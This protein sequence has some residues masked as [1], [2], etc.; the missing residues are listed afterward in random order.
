M[1]VPA[2]L[3]PVGIATTTVPGSVYLNTASA[4]PYAVISDG[5]NGTAIANGLTRSTAG[6]ISIGTNVTNDTSIQMCHDAASV[7]MY[8][9]GI[10]IG[11]SSGVN[12][13]VSIGDA[14]SVSSCSL[15][16][17]SQITLATAA[18]GGTYFI[19]RYLGFGS[20]ST[21]NIGST[22]VGAYTINIGASS[23]ST[24]GVY[25]IGTGL[26]TGTTNTIN[27]GTGHAGTGASAI[28][29][30]NALGKA[31][32]GTATAG[33]DNILTLAT[34]GY[35]DDAVSGGVL[36][37]A[38]TTVAGKI[39]LNTASA[40]PYAVI[41]DGLNG[42]AIAN[43]LT[44]STAGLL[45]IGTNAT[46]DTSITIGSATIKARSGAATVGA[47]N[48]LTLA[49][50]G[51][52]DS[53]AGGAVS[54][55]TTTV[56]GTVY[57]NSAAV[58]PYA[59]IS[60]G[61]GGFAVAGGLTRGSY[62][63][64]ALSIGNQAVDTSIVIGSGSA[65]AVGLTGSAININTAGGGATNIGNASAGALSVTADHL[66]ITSTFTGGG[67]ANLNTIMVPASQP[68]LIIDTL[69]AGAVASIIC[70]NNGVEGIVINAATGQIT[71]K[72]ATTSGD[73]SLVLATKGYV[74]AV[75]SA[76]WTLITSFNGTYSGTVRVT[77]N[78][79]IASMR[80]YVSSGITPGG[81]IPFTLGAAFRPSSYASSHFTQCSDGTNYF[82]SQTVINTA[83][84]V[85]V[86]YIPTYG[87][88]GPTSIAAN[89][90]L[91]LD[92]M[93]RI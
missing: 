19:G 77:V 29:I 8:G 30:G 34:K 84:D 4:T 69:T 66:Y 93:W 51:Y 64:G 73:T 88:S 91:Y 47:D 25:N 92:C 50:K 76:V 3:S 28:T 9:H 55:A 60:D 86:T 87:T 70:Y 23:A 54:I 27:I 82:M 85:T 16:S 44:R 14:T 75:G 57:L 71:V 61:I 43:G 41:S 74:D 6:A 7:R 21:I 37:L 46:N 10:T 68:G 38:T 78:N 17:S 22:D 89:M 15:Y 20:T 13:F 42:T 72:T 2:G 83:G 1:S 35:V 58:T 26:S 81:N 31:R 80:G 5:L 53:T 62:G 18:T 63:A 49:T 45:S 33:G 39:Y 65:T 24:G 59:V 36:S 79:G 48:S 12:G 90:L 11:K 67:T 40:T 52:V 56:A 32:A